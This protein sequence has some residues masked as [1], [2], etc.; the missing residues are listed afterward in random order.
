V[1][2]LD[3]KEP[4]ALTW[5]KRGISEEL[6][7]APNTHSDDDI[8]VL[9]VFLESDILNISLCGFVRLGVDRDTVDQVLRTIPKTDKEFT[10]WTYLPYTDESLIREILW[11]PPEYYHP[12]SRFRMLLSLMKKNGLHEMA[13][14][15]V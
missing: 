12:T 5:M 2:D 14:H 10:A 7:L 3:G 6:G 8:R 15:W 11:P 9:S 4:A 13:S 1:A